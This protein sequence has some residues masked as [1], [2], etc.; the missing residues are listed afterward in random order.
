MKCKNCGKEIAD[1]DLFCEFCGAKQ[2]S[3]SLIC[4]QCGTA[5]EKDNKFCISCGSELS[6]D[7]SKVKKI[8]P[9]IKEEPKKEEP[10]EDIVSK[11]EIDDVTEIN[12]I[13]TEE[14]KK[15]SHALLIIL[16]S[17]AVLAVIG[18]VSYFVFFKGGFSSSK[19]V[20]SDKPETTEVENK[21]DDKQ[22]TAPETNNETTEN[23]TE[24]VSSNYYVLEAID[25]VRVRSYSTTD[26][27]QVGK[28]A[29]GSTIR[30][31]DYRDG[32]DGL[33]WYCINNGEWV[34]ND[35]T[36]FKVTSLT[37]TNK[38]DLLS[39]SQGKINVTK[40]TMVY[41]SPSLNASTSGWLTKT[42]KMLYYDKISAD[43]KTWLQISCD[44]FVLYDYVEYYYK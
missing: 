2:D 4:P 13:L 21:D 9:N 34:A 44:G 41:T 8:T 28:I 18:V 22:D 25:N 38:L 17:V 23:K 20:T 37:T 10:K 24:Q 16:I 12:P 30:A 5:N 39:G 32:D 27:D 31:Y 1:N 14:P 35:G 26:S 6:S 11:P 19:V 7:N 15:K 36:F 29:K 3:D 40:D 42:T 43:G 33:S